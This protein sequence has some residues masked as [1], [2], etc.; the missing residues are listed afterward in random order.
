[1]EK[2]NV[3]V[4]I[5][6]SFVGLHQWKNCPI[7]EVSFLKDL[8]RHNFYVSVQLNQLEHLDRAVEFIML[9]GD[10]D[11]AIDSLYGNEKIKNL[12]SKSCEMMAE[13]I[14]SKLEE[15]YKTPMV[16]EVS[17]DKEFVGGIEFG[18]KE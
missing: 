13:D 14:H 12:G 7:K 17:E 4:R 8:H 6:T 10:V 1:M 5:N 2:K 16:I 18:V 15:K 3:Y 11:T 9:K